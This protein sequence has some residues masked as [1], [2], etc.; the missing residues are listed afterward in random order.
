MLV[1]A[2]DHCVNSTGSAYPVTFIKFYYTPD[3]YIEVVNNGQ[4][5]RQDYH[6][7]AKMHAPQLAF[8]KLF[9]GTNLKKDKT[10]IT[11]G[12]NG[13]GA[14]L[15]NI[16]SLEFLLE[17]IYNHIDGSR[18][19]YK[20]KWHNH[21]QQVD[22][23]T[24]EN[25][26]KTPYTSIKFLPDYYGEF[27]YGKDTMTIAEIH[28][29]LIDVFR[30][31]T[32]RL[33]AYIGW[34]S[35]KK[36]KVYFNDVLVPVS[37]MCDLAKIMFPGEPILSM[38]I[39]PDNDEFCNY[40]WEIH[41]VITESDAKSG[42]GK[43][44]N[45]ISNVNGVATIRGGKHVDYIMDQIVG[46]IKEKLTKELKT[47]KISFQPSYVSSN[48]VL[49]L[50]TKIP[51][52]GWTGQRKDEATIPLRGKNH[53]LTHYE[54]NKKFLDNT[55]RAIKD[56]IM[57]RICDKSNETKNK[58]KK[59]SHDKY[60]SAELAGTKYSQE[61]AL[62][63]P[64]GDSAE[65]LVKKG[66]TYTPK[67][68]KEPLMG[69]FK[70]NGIFTLG[71]VI[72]NVRKCIKIIVT[73][74]GKKTK[75][76]TQKL[77]NNKF[78]GPFLEITGLDI[79]SEYDP[80]SATYAAEMK[81]LRYGCIIGFVDQ[82]K[83]GIGK[84]FSLILSMFQYVWPNLLS[85]GYVKRFATPLR[86][87]M[88]KAGGAIIE[89]FTD[90]EYERWSK[91]VDTN[92]YRID[93]VKGLASNEIRD[94]YYMFENF[95]KRIY[96]YYPD[97]F[98]DDIFDK[99]FGEDAEKRKV[100]LRTPLDVPSEE[101][102]RTQNQL[103][104]ISCTHHTIYEAKAQKK[105]DLFQKLWSAIDGMN[106]S[107]RK[108][109]YGASIIFRS[110]NERMKIASMVGDIMTKT[111]YHHGDQSLAKSIIAKS[112]ISTGGIQL[113][114]LTPCSLGHGT[115]DE[116]GSNQ[117]GPRYV[118][119]KYNKKL[120]NL[121]IPNDE[122]PLL[123]YVFDEG[124]RCEPKYFI[125]ILPMAVLESTEMPANGWKI[126]TWARDVFAVIATVKKMIYGA[127][128]S[129]LNLEL[130]PL[131]YD[132]RGYK[133]KFT[134][135]SGELYSV[136]CYERKGNTIIITDLPLRVWTKTFEETVKKEKKL[137][138]IV[139]DS[140]DENIN[141]KISFISNEEFKKLFPNIHKNY[142]SAEDYVAKNYC[143]DYII[144]YLGLKSKIDSNLNMIGCLGEVIEFNTYIEI[145]KYWFPFRKELYIKRIERIR[146]LLQLE[147]QL[148]DNILRYV[149]NYTKMEIS[150]VEEDVAIA[151]LANE[152]FDKLNVSVI[153]SPG[154]LTNEE[155]KY[156][157]FN[158]NTSYNYLLDTT[159][160][161]KL[162]PAINKFKENIAKLHNELHQLNQKASIGQF[163]G[164]AFWIEELDK[165]EEVIKE[166][167]T[168]GWQFGDKNKF[169][170]KK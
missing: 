140:E 134:Y 27:G 91:T 39:K 131:K 113:P 103:M 13:I 34:H 19:I 161:Q 52:V 83:D 88:P 28:S 14:K 109:V 41:A 75:K 54:L 121:L 165:L 154:F 120:M 82:D 169:Y 33:A 145:I 15:P 48:I 77:E 136:G 73:K 62:G 7:G 129:K 147:I 86:R 119:S 94:V 21:M 59:V 170:Y 162:T 42:S 107:G 124:D 70:K 12:T 101:L 23:P 150:K 160:R 133:G 74:N 167:F 38:E 67:G 2:S 17:T 6:T 90:A 9:K 3:G 93:Y 40:P 110:T 10:S 8:G 108:I 127:D 60:K 76:M 65:E 84:I 128:L 144:E 1:N 37:N 44:H 152:K 158:E 115:R 72:I 104:K 100:E 26:K 137:V 64:E 47:E 89:F 58:K 139:N 117:G 125:P 29:T 153:R 102:L 155:I 116:G 11:G 43:T 24:I 87:A 4:G 22:V 163:E 111:N 81:K 35:T 151:K 141:I 157:A 61:C 95:K 97:D 78:F 68:H 143:D 112:F 168:T 106:E 32:Y 164:A 156:K 159:D 114:V 148:L 30:M 96:T 146:L 55:A 71:G 138:E 25:T 126:K 36:C 18:T 31:R 130:P 16:F 51:G 5:V 57:E 92:K 132:H 46:H 118:Y 49:F 166:G 20:Q 79:N 142:A 50:N 105:E 123:D 85:A 63:L 56:K 98:T 135:I 45:Q 69:G 99:F 149:L 80:K 122:L 66:L 53:Q